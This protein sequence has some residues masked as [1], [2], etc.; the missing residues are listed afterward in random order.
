MVSRK[1]IAITKELARRLQKKFP[2]YRVYANKCPSRGTKVRKIWFEKFHEECP[3]LQPEMDIIILEP[4]NPHVLPRK[5]K[6]R[7][8]EIKYFEKVDGSINQSFYKGIEQSLALL[9]WG[10]DNVALWQLFD[11]S[12]SNDDLRNYGCRTWFYIHVILQLPIEFTMIQVIGKEVKNL[13]FQVIQANWQN[14]LSPIRLLNID[15][16]YFTFSHTHPN[17]FIEEQLIKEFTFTP[18][19]GLIPKKMPPEI[20][21]LIK[22]VATLRNFLLDWLPKQSHGLKK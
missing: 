21:K 9:Q 15:H 10:F 20:E 17:P 18:Q 3:P 2:N 19:I 8:I 1:E 6:I 5:P 14:N 22:E 13:Q 16:P 12:F 7:A 11:E 4:P